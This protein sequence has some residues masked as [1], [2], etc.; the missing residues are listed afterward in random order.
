MCD[1]RETLLTYLYDEGDPIERR[2]VETHLETCETCREELN[3]LQ[4]VR[5]D[6]LAWDVPPHESV[7]KPFTPARP[8]WS[9]RD[10]PAWTMAAAAGLMLALGAAG[11]AAA[12][13][14]MGHQPAP[15]TMASVA[16]QSV[17]PTAT[18][19]SRAM[20]VTL[21]PA[22][23]DRLKQSLL[24]EIDRRDHAA[25]LRAA[26]DN[27]ELLLAV[28]NDYSG[29]LAAKTKSDERI[30]NLETLVSGL[31]QDQQGGR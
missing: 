26:A 8:G 5:E 16:A 23:L 4:H 22:D 12:H 3:G 31:L 13:T 1:E 10:V 25:A 19:V 24:A 9:F 18:N 20:P 29:M 21:T 27:N 28:M 15:V 2:R 7:W 30:K 17:V 14:W 11:G 6:L